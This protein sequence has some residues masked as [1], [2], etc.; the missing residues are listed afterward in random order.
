M[1]RVIRYGEKY[2]L[3]ERRE[4]EGREKEREDREREESWFYALPHTVPV[5]VP[6]HRQNSFGWDYV[7]FLSMG[8][9]IS[10]GKLLDTPRP[11]YRR[12]TK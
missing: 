6:V 10:F 3:R 11:D 4:R 5:P 8:V 9:C 12:C 7:V 1:L 2:K